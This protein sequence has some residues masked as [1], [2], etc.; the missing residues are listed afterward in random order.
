MR[1]TVNP[2]TGK[3]YWFRFGDIK[4]YTPKQIEGIIGSLA[5]GGESG[6]VAVIR[7][8]TKPASKFSSGGALNL[9]EI[10]EFIIYDPVEVRSILIN[11]NQ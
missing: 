7:I 9:A 6:G 11:R 8:S 3:S 10:P 5:S 4:N 2:P 1:S